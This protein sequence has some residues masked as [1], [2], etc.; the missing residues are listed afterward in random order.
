MSLLE[1][2]HQPPV[3][4]IGPKKEWSLLFKTKDNVVP[5]GLSPLLDVSDQ[6]EQLL[7]SHLLT[8]LSNSSLIAPLK[9]MVAVVVS[10]ML[11]SSMLRN[12]LLRLLPTTHI[13]QEPPKLLDLACTPLPREPELSLDTL[14]SQ[15]T[16]S[17]L[18]RTLL[19]LVQSLLPSKPVKLLSNTT[20]P[21]LL[22]PAVEPH[23]ITV[24]LLSD[25]ELIPLESNTSSSRTNGVLLGVLMDISKS[26]PSIPTFA[27]FSLT[28]PSL[29]S[30]AHEKIEK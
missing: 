15:L 25:G 18:L 13:H 1:L 8:T 2:T 24:S 11:L 17:L 29:P 12:L 26:V 20:P 27:V 30:Q 23:S 4:L 19:P 22:P 28:H 21:V 14:T 10:W 3:E 16:A 5:A 7:D 9:T 6:E